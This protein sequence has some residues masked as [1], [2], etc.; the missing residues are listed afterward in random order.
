MNTI[1]AQRNENILYYGGSPIFPFYSAIFDDGYF[2]SKI[3]SGANNNGVE[4]YFELDPLYVEDTHN[5]MINNVIPGSLATTFKSEEFRQKIASCIIP[6]LLIGPLVSYYDSNTH[7]DITSACAIDL[8]PKSINRFTYTEL[9]AAISEH[10]AQSSSGGE[11]DLGYI[12]VCFYLDVYK[13]VG[14]M[15]DAGLTFGMPAYQCPML[16]DIKINNMYMQKLVIPYI[17]PPRISTASIKNYINDKE[18]S[19]DSPYTVTDKAKNPLTGTSYT[20]TDTRG[21]SH[22]INGF[23]TKPSL[24]DLNDPLKNYLASQEGTHNLRAMNPELSLPTGTTIGIFKIAANK[25]V[26]NIWGYNID[27]EYSDS[28][29][30]YGLTQFPVSQKGSVIHATD[31]GGMVVFI[32]ETD[33]L[34]AGLTQSFLD[35]QSEYSKYN[36]IN[37]DGTTY[38]GYS[39]LRMTSGG[40]ISGSLRN[41]DANYPTILDKVFMTNPDTIIDLYAFAYMT[42]WNTYI[43]TRTGPSQLGTYSY[44]PSQDAMNIITNTIGIEVL[45]ATEGAFQMS[46]KMETVFELNEVK[47]VAYLQVG[48]SIKYGSSGEYACYRIYA[49]KDGKVWDYLGDSIGMSKTI[50]SNSY[51]QYLSIDISN[52]AEPDATKTYSKIKGKVLK[53]SIPDN[54]M[55]LRDTATG[56][57]TNIVGSKEFAIRDIVI[58]NLGTVLDFTLSGLTKLTYKDVIYENEAADTKFAQL[59]KDT[60]FINIDFTDLKA[61][62]SELLIDLGSEKEF[63][64]VNIISGRTVSNG[65]QEMKYAITISSDGSTFKDVISM[66]PATF[67]EE[68]FL[69]RTGMLVM[70]NNCFFTDDI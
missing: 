34:A 43:C 35:T 26:G 68:M 32:K 16:F 69:K 6:K 42:Y 60:D 30:N 23:K 15:V 5:D 37:P 39:V 12:R 40:G 49:S 38:A 65:I 62:G 11:L 66:D 24:Q 10:I 59:L 57:I 9:T 70:N 54:N 18:L 50:N 53:V 63:D 8:T 33:L 44:K 48:T 58:N 64:T 17:E 2:D 21:N 46:D 19:F 41:R 67:T 27:L 45:T 22:T 1:T 29:G 20:F 52:I 47:E 25:F 31:F 13:Y 56:A 28:P 4:I 3:I 7:S 55:Y 14:M 36:L 51:Y 61:E